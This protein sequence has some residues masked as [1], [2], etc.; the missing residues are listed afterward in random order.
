MPALTHS[1]KRHIAKRLKI[2]TKSTKS[3]F[4]TTAWDTRKDSIKKRVAKTEATMHGYAVERK[5][6]HVKELIDSG[7]ICGKQGKQICFNAVGPS[8]HKGKHSFETDKE[9]HDRRS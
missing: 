5:E 6:S 7:A 2:E 9:Y 4:E 1:A 3:L 8:G